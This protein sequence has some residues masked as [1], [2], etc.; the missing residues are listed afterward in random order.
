MRN[1][2]FDLNFKTIFTQTLLVTNEHYK[3]D[4]NVIFYT[5]GVFDVGGSTVS[6]DP[7][8]TEMLQEWRETKRSSVADSTDC[9]FRKKERVRDAFTACLHQVN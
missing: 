4:I 7:V 6:R 2:T 5:Y 1:R 8:L 9:G 3:I